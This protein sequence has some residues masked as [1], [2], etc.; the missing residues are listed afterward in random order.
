MLNASG[1]DLEYSVPLYY[2]SYFYLGNCYENL[3][4]VSK[5][6]TTG[7]P[8]INL[9][10]LKNQIMMTI[11]KDTL[12]H[13]ILNVKQINKMVYSPILNHRCDNAQTKL[14]L[15]HIKDINCIVISDSYDKKNSD[16]FYGVAIA[17][18][19]K[20]L[21]H[22]LGVNELFFQD[23]YVQEC[24]EGFSLTWYDQISLDDML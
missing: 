12:H 11:S 9:F 10:D 17:V 14:K 4:V 13:D 23:S 5:K 20:H 19:D 1:Y 8:I 24:P 7:L 2:T 15:I 3:L 22:L 16:K 6:D 21:E 18:K